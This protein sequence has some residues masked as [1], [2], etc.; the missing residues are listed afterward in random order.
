MI[1]KKAIGREERMK[2]LL[3]LGASGH[4]G[5]YLFR[6]FREDGYTVFG[7]SKTPERCSAQQGMLFYSLE[8]GEEA[9][10]SVLGYSK[11]GGC[12]FLPARGFCTAAGGA[13][14]PCGLSSGS[15]GDKACLPVDGKR[16]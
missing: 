12:Y 10:Q 14:I 11:T 5:G 4:I 9:L 16:L 3:I 7:T 13:P 8:K 6:Q 15:S 1:V 2:R